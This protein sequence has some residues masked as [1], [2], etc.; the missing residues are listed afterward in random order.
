[1]ITGDLVYMKAEGEIL[2]STL[3][4]ITSSVSQPERKY[5]VLWLDEASDGVMGWYQTTSLH[6]LGDDEY[7]EAW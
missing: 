3:G 5:Q 7:E 2:Q 6:P 1:M 4:V